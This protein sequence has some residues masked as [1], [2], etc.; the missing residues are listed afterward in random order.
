MSWSI[1]DMCG[2]PH[3]VS[4]SNKHGEG[5]SCEA[6]RDK[7]KPVLTSGSRPTREVCQKWTPRTRVHGE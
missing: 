3:S 4:W 7:D 1:C 6:M 5:L 2:Q